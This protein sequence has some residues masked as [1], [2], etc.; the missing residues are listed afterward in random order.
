MLLVRG[1]AETICIASMVIGRGVLAPDLILNI[2]PGL[3]NILPGLD[4][5]SA[6]LI[7]I[8]VLCQSRRCSPKRNGSE[9][10]NCRFFEHCPNSSV[11]DP[12]GSRGDGLAVEPE[13]ALGA[14]LQAVLSLSGDVV[15]ISCAV[16]WCSV[17]DLQM[18]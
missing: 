18:L 14:E 4:L 17:G 11:A 9:K 6:A 8:T 12:C 16:W 7:C 15:N 2:F 10:S 3:L 5:K 13:V 1:P